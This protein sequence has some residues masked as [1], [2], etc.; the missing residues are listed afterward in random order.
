M[1]LALTLSTATAPKTGKWVALIHTDGEVPASWSETLRKAAESVKD[2]RVWTEPPAVTLGEAQSALGCAGWGPACAA[3]VAQ[4]TGATTAL[5]VD[6]TGTGAGVGLSTEAVL[7]GSGQPA[8]GKNEVLLPDTSDDSLRYAAAW[9]KG[10]L[11][12]KLPAL[13]IVDT[14]TP[15]GEVRLDGKRAGTTDKG[16]VRIVVESPGTHTLLVTKEGAAPVTRD[17]RLAPNETVKEL[18]SLSAEGPPVDPGVRVGDPKVITPK[19]PDAPQP[20]ATLDTSGAVVGWSVTGVGAVVTLAAATFAG[21]VAWDL[22]FARTPCGANDEKSC[23][24]QTVTNPLGLYHYDAPDREQFFITD[25]PLMLSLA[26]IGVG[27]GGLLAGTGI[28][29]ALAG[30]AEAVEGAP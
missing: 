3:Q 10:S 12:D 27:V 2:G 9:V 20:P 5:L 26:A 13:L 11:V 6:V 4:M 14:A 22:Y 15:G 25:G 29:L 18:V 16:P 17:V 7:A 19:P 8:K 28:W 1:V 30:P 24:P 23:V 21:T